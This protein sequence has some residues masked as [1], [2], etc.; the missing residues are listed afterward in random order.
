MSESKDINDI[1][2]E[3]QHLIMWGHET[4]DTCLASTVLSAPKNKTL[5]TTYENKTNNNNN[6]NNK[7]VSLPNKNPSKHD[8]DI[9]KKEFADLVERGNKYDALELFSKHTSFGQHGAAMCTLEFDEKQKV[10]RLK[11]VG[12]EGDTTTFR[13]VFFSNGRFTVTC[14]PK[15]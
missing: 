3:N 10:V 7:I 9:L 4:L 8:A 2:Q 15:N 11:T 6:A 1:L 12:T 14:E 5:Q 13:I